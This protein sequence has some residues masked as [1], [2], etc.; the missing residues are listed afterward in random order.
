MNSDE[1]VDEQGLGLTF[2]RLVVLAVRTVT[3]VE[4]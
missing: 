4:A 3:W 2:E 1:F